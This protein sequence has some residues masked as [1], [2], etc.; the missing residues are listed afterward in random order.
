MSKLDTHCQLHIQDH[1]YMVAF[2]Y[3]NFLGTWMQIFNRAGASDK[4]SV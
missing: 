3:E 4:L 1:L 2:K